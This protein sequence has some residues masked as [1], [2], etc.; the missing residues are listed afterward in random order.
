MLEDSEADAKLMELA[1]E[2]IE[3]SYQ[4]QVVNDPEV[5]LESLDQLI[6]AEEVPVSLLLFLLDLEV[7]KLSGL[8]LIEKIRHRFD[9]DH[10][11]IVVYS[12]SQNTKSITTAYHHGA[13]AYLFKSINYLETVAQLDGMLRYYLKVYE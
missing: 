13:N 1:L 5:L 2:E 12:G 11:P 8:E 7:P 9:K 6:P 10:F 3:I 4:L